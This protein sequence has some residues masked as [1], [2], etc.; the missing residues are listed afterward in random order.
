MKVVHFDG[1]SCK[2]LG[3]KRKNNPHDPFS[4]ISGEILQENILG[5][6]FR[7]YNTL[8]VEAMAKNYV[9]KIVSSTEYKH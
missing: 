7:S 6:N 4:G 8:L 5:I 3:E 1:T 9:V 2:T